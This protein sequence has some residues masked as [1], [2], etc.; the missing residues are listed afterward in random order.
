MAD[1]I[2]LSC[3]ELTELVNAY[4]EGTLPESER[5]RFDAHLATCAGCRTYLDQMRR[6]VA[7]TSMLRDNT[8]SD[9][10]R[11]RLL[12][13]FRTWKSGLPPDPQ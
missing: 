9:E 2:E 13:A 4:L 5:A 11:D 7:M 10:A 6:T 12:A 3:Q 1:T 8:L